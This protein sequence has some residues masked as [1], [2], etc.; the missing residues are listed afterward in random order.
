MPWLDIM[1]L[2]LTLQQCFVS[3]FWRDKFSANK[4][5]APLNNGSLMDFCKH[6]P[7]PFDLP[8]RTP[9]LHLP[10]FLGLTFYQKSEVLSYFGGFGL[11]VQSSYSEGADIDELLNNLAVKQ[12][13]VFSGYVLLRWFQ[14]VVAENWEGGY[15]C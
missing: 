6:T 8:L 10:R 1:H 13:N 3:S 15:L 7:S 12:Y 4:Y 5:N 2:C 11:L 14:S 9:S